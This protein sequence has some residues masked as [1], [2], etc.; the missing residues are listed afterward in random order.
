MDKQHFDDAIGEVPPPTFDVDGLVTRGRRAVRLQ[1][2]ASPAAAAT[3]A[4]VVLTGAVALTM[5]GEDL[6]GWLGVG[7]QPTSSSSNAPAPT[8]G[9]ATTGK[10]L[11]QLPMPEGCSRPDLESVTEVEERITA[12]LREAIKDQR[13]DLEFTANPNAEYPDNVPHGPLEFYRVTEHNST[14]DQSICA[15]GSYFL[16]RATT[17]GTEGEGNILVAVTPALFRPGVHGCTTFSDASRSCEMHT[18]PQG[19][20]IVTTTEKYDEGTRS[21]RV[22]IYRPDGTQVMISVEDIA[23]TIKSGGPPTATALP[24]TLDQLVVIGTDDGLTLFP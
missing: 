12:Q 5:N 18:G 8:S 15:D 6:G 9:P 7:D 13:A 22:D 10:A 19:E 3:T 4:V 2:L 24:L 21:N 11:P 23:D 20:I 14:L 1:R 17:I 16:A